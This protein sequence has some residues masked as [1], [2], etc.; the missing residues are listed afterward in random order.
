[1]NGT[2]KEYALALFAVG[3][4]NSSCDQMHED[5]NL[6]KDVVT[7]TPGYTVYLSDPA[8]PKSERIEKLTEA[9]E[10]Q[11]GEDILSFLCVLLEH[12]DM[13]ILGNAIDEFELMYENY[14]HYA[15]AVITSV[16]ELDDEQ[17][18]RLEA[19][20]MKSTGKRIEAEYVIEPNIIGGITVTVD[21]MYYDGSVK[22]NLKNIKEVMS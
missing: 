5:L 14:K 15:R 22:K 19:N 12:G 20:L 18:K 7:S 6:V 1:M 21:G 13:A 10:N 3:I 9:W 16:V 11:V 8:I 2:G 17:K 4:E